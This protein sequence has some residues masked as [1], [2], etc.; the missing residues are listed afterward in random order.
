MKLEEVVSRLKLYKTESRKT[1]KEI[2]AEAGVS[3]SLIEKLC[4]GY[5]RNPTLSTLR[6]LKDYLEQNEKKAA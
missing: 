3:R 5:R 4:A 2:A 1:Y 6:I